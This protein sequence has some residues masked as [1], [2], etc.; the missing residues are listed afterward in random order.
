MHVVVIKL[1]RLSNIPLT[2]HFCIYVPSSEQNNQQ[3][4]WLD[5]RSGDGT[6]KSENFCW[7]LKSVCGC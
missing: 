3:M 5:F 1:L 2:L 6:H 7:A 4:L